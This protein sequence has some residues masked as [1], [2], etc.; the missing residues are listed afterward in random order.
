MLAAYLISV[1]VLHGMLLA[2]TLEGIAILFGSLKVRAAA[3]ELGSLV[4]YLVVPTIRIGLSKR[5]PS[6]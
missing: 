4:Q 6:L 1:M 2:H 5:S 3:I